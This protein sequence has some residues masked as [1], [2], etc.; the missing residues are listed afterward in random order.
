MAVVPD[1]RPL[2]LPELASKVTASPDRD[3]H[4]Q[5]KIR[6]QSRL[7]LPVDDEGNPQRASTGIAAPTAAYRDSRYSQQ[8]RGHHRQTWPE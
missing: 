6:A 8:L 4:Q 2:N 3:I 5:G 7:A 1:H